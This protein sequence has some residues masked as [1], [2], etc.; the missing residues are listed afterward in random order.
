MVV[1]W[2]L[3]VLMVVVLAFSYMVREDTRATTAFKEGAEEKFLAEGGIER[4]AVE[5]MY[6]KINVGAPAEASRERDVWST[7]GTPAVFSL[8]NGTCLVRIIDESG[9][10]DLNKT[11]EIVMKG[12]LLN[13]GVK[14]ETADGIVDSIQDWRD[15]D[16]F[17]RLHGAESDYYMSLPRPYKAKN[18]DFESVEELLLVKGVTYE[19]LYGK[20]DKP[21]LADFVTV[22]SESGKINIGAAPREVL[23]ALPGMTPET[24][25]T[26]MEYRKNPD[27]R[28]FSGI[29]N[30]IGQAYSAMSPYVIVGD[31]N[32]FSVESVGRKTSNKAG[33][34]IKAVMSVSGSKFSYKYYRSPWDM[35]RWKEP[36]K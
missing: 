23:M 21:G 35:T 33:Y 25:A 9:K 34:G 27:I 3:A 17:V 10:V 29:Q 8:E 1:M 20:G 5:I 18:A 6:R 11:P 22:Y 26:V 13:L 31:S 4:A 15:P 28:V 16:D 2:G 12:L 24:A 32:T 14:E 7:D 30:I 19:L 36:E